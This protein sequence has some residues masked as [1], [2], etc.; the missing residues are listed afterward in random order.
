MI[1]SCLNNL[2]AELDLLSNDAIFL[3][4]E[5]EKWTVFSHETR[6]KL[7]KISPDAVYAFNNSP[8]ILF[9]DL[10]NNINLERERDIHKQVWSFDQAP[11]MF[12]VKAEEV[13]IYNAF[14]YEKKVKKE[15]SHLQEIKL[16]PEESRKEIFSFWKLQSGD[17]W[18]WL[19]T[20]YYENKK[21]N[22]R[23]KRVHQKLFD[24]IKLVR[25]KL[26]SNLSDEDANTLILRLIF[27]RYLIDRDVKIDPQFIKGESIVEKRISFSSL[28]RDTQK[29]NSFFVELNRIFNG[30]LFKEKL[31]LTTEQSNYLANVFNEKDDFENQTLFDNT[32][33]YFNVF[34][35]NIIPVELI[36]G[37]Y[38]SL[39]SP[40]TREADSAFYT[41]LFLVEHILTQTIDRFLDDK[42]S[43]CK[44]FDPA[45][46]S[47]IFL[48]QSFRRMVER[49][50]IIL[51]ETI[52]SK[53]RL[54]EIAKNNLFGIDKNPEAL[55][56]ACFSIYL[57]ILDYEDPGTIMD[58]FHFPN[59]N[60]FHANFFDT[61]HDFNDKIKS[62]NIDYI[63]GNPPWRNGSDDPIHQKYLK[64]NSLLKIVSDFQLAQSFIIRTKDF[65][66]SQTKIAL[67]V[68]SK[69][70]Y[71]SNAKAFRT[72]FLNDFF[73]NRCFDLSAVNNL[74]F[75]GAGNPAMV[76]FFE[77]ANGVATQGNVVEHVSIK[78]NIYLK[79]YKTLVLERNDLKIIQQKHFIN[80]EWM[81]KVALY[82]GVLDYLFLKNLNSDYTLKEYIKNT[83]GLY[84]GDGIKLLTEYGRKK[85][86]KESLPFNEIKDIPIIETGDILKYYTVAD[87]Q[88]LPQEKDLYI[89]SGNDINLYKGNRILIKA[90]PKNNT[91]IVYSL[92][93]GDSVFRE[94]TLGISTI[95]KNQELKI[96]Y[97]IIS[98]D[99]YAYFQFITSS[100]LGIFMPE[101]MQKEYLNFPY[102][103]V[104]DKIEF[105]DCISKRIVNFTEISTNLSFLTTNKPKFDNNLIEKINLIINKTYLVDS[106]K[107][108]LIDYVLKIS[109]YQFKENKI[110]EISEF[111]YLD[112]TDYRNF[113][114]VIRDYTDVFFS[115]LEPIYSDEFI[116]V[117]V[118]N[119]DHFIALN[120][121]FSNEK[122]IKRIVDG[123]G[124]DEKIVLEKIAKT[125]SISQISKDLFIQ[126]DIKGFEENSFYIIKPNE[127]KCWHRAMAWYDVAEIKEAIQTA[128][129][130]RLKN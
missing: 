42:K 14:A 104:T 95:N 41:P 106:Y 6:T 44:I 3:L 17:T 1:N 9:F 101:I 99:L 110:K 77:Y 29:L 80:H 93:I 85:Q 67:I 11:L 33:F 103:E 124:K 52:I 24:N 66:S 127:Y 86:K 112:K 84:Y 69:A 107:L 61:E 57:A 48:V 87:K 89:K 128:E 60:L 8:Y 72:Y 25:E 40:E 96:V 100:S 63:L 130:D 70:I 15:E 56:V 2:L 122:P 12:I 75:E 115:E 55:K 45:V 113:D 105:I 53:M 4:N 111:T 10:T 28:I 94:K 58:E 13:K 32:E 43:E 27:I 83:E 119:L 91:D 120:F 81:F 97:G 7:L 109:R 116:S 5:K 76:L 118:Y 37:I 114:K 98:S 126:K 125:V 78:H 74:I 39:I 49:E 31:L 123:K 71:N 88:N 73:L 19:Q 64:N 34:D 22:D 23:K 102:K 79:R 121:V 26:S 35:F 59:L 82:G 117:E 36:S 21:L 92:V 68:T 18:K 90:R 16:G 51:G 62:K 30:V 20:K 50:K 38:E 65:S 129:L 47:G 108:D 46:G 54:T